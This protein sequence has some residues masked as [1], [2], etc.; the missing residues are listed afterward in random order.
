M[1][2][3]KLRNEQL[4]TDSCGEGQYCEDQKAQV[5]KMVEQ[6]SRSQA[7]HVSKIELLPSLS[8]MRTRMEVGLR[9]LNQNL[10]MLVY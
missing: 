4:F 9:Q 10:G 1:N 3:S 7:H 6:Q 8:G 5:P 2:E